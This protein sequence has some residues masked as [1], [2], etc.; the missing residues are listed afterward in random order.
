PIN[1]ADQ[2][3]EHIERAFDEHEAHRESSVEFRH[4]GP[5]CWAWAQDWAQ[6]SVDRPEGEPLPAWEPVYDAEPAVDHVSYAL[7][8]ALGRFHADGG[9]IAEHAP[10]S[11]LPRGV[12]FLSAAHPER[13]LDSPAC[14]P[15][16]RAWGAHGPDVAP[17]KG[18][19]EWLRLHAFK[20]DHLKRYEHRP[21]Y[22]PLSSA[23]RTFVT[24]VSIHRFDAQ[25]LPYLL[26]EHL[27]D[28]QDKLD[29]E[30]EDLRHAG[31]ERDVER[32]NRL[33]AW[34]D[35]LEDYRTQVRQIAEAGP[36]AA[37]PADPP[38][39]EDAPYHLHLDD[40]VMI[41]AAALWPL[42]GPQGWKKPR[43]WWSELCRAKGKK[44]Y[45]WSRTAA[46]YFPQ[47]VAEKC[48]D[49][50]SLA[51]AHGS[52]WRNHPAKAYAWE[53]RLQDEIGPDF[54]LDEADSDALRAAFL[55]SKPG[56]AADIEAAE[57][58]RREKKRKK[59]EKEQAAALTAKSKTVTGPLFEG[60][61]P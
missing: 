34:R 12:L 33:L 18:L 17:K 51:V 53:L 55:E 28:A 22:F 32:E 27:R 35:E 31:D 57:M 59:E 43:A 36:P 26:A 46:R 23:K 42:L 20:D 1:S 11:A 3:F 30:L 15:L 49:D 50:P 19:H 38:R 14:E 13:D 7:G 25:T 45:D 48:R 47:R 9:G 54:T 2:I 16:R 44:D 61:A 24:W 40:G 29:G 56:E 52:F 8:V 58:K 39:E 41:H 4:P 21:S 60:P 10:D 6:R 37:H 5:S